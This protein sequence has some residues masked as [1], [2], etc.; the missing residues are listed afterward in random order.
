MDMH[1]FL[2][3][4]VQLLILVPGAASCYLAA[5]DRMRFSYAK[6]AALC[7]AVLIPYSVVV[8]SVYA[9]FYID[10]NI[11]LLPSLI[12]FFFLYPYSEH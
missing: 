11:I 3:G 10:I 12:L 8:T 5:K 2:S 4:L 9:L 7:A 1:K 6:T